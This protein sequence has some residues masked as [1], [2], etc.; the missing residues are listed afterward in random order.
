MKR[1]IEKDSELSCG[2]RNKRMLTG[3]HENGRKQQINCVHVKLSAL[4]AECEKHY[5]GNKWF[6]II[7]IFLLMSMSHE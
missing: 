1:L 4:A 2:E 7:E 3:R 6:K 5:K